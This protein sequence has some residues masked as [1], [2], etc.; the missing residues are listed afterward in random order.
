MVYT[1][2]CDCGTEKTVRG[3][4]LTN[5]TT[6]SCGCLFKDK[7]KEA[8]GHGFFVSS[9][10]DRRFYTIWAMMK[11]RCHNPNQP[12]YAR[13]GARG[14]LVCERWQTFENFR[15]DMFD[16]YREHR[17]RYGARNTSIDRID[18]SRGYSPDNCRW[19][20]RSVQA[21]NKTN[22][23]HVVYKN[24]K[25]TVSEF[26]AIYRVTHERF[27]SAESIEE[28]LFRDNEKREERRKNIVLN[29]IFEQN[30]GLDRKFVMKI[31]RGEGF[32]LEE[33]AKKFGLTRQ[34]VD[35]IVKSI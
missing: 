16:K 10:F 33:I 28:L 27:I 18:N 11:Q 22:N 13:Y 29:E 4:N 5:G 9:D 6:Q 19:A 26:C 35:Q 15:E 34:R 31:M 21:N 3:F 25:Y 1:V 23:R 30:K 2:R 7:A 12:A 17:D 24:V 8:K 20:T 14:I 32:T